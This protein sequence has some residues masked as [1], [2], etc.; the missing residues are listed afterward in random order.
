MNFRYGKSY[1]RTVDESMREFIKQQVAIDTRLRDLQIANNPV[2]LSKMR[3]EEEVS[4]AL[5]DYLDRTRFK[6]IKTILQFI[7]PSFYV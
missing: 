4:Q 6:G 1:G 7:S 5:R 3:N 2:L